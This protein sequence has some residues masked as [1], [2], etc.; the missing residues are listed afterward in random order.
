M[1]PMDREHKQNC[2]TCAKTKLTRSSCKVNLVGHTDNI[3]VHVEIWGPM[4]TTTYGGMRYFLTL[5]ATPHRNVRV[6]LLKA[7]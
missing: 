6:Q 1:I 7:S 4:H 3:T 5:T 2:S